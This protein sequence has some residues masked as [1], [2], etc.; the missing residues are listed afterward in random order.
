MHDEVRAQCALL[1]GDMELLGEIA[2]LRE[3]GEL[4]Q[5]PQRQLAPATSHLRAPQRRH[6]IAR[7][8]LQLGLAARERMRV[9]LRPLEGRPQRL[10]ELRDGGLALLQAAR[11]ERLLAPERLA[12]E[13]QEELAV[14]AQR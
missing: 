7:L 12:R 13:L 3:A 11:G 4:H 2:M 5:P 9:L 6:E 10:D 8:P 14:G 1:T